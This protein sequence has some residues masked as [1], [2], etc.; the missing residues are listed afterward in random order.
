[1]IKKF[2]P[3]DFRKQDYLFWPKFINT[4]LVSKNV[5]KENFNSIQRA[6]NSIRAMSFSLPD[7]DAQ[8]I[9]KDKS[10]I[11]TINNLPKDVVIIKSG[12]THGIVLSKTFLVFIQ[13][14][15]I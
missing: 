13:I 14:P 5:Q 3:V 12:K 2:N 8:Q 4:I 11:A 6:K 15:D 10:K 9:I 1:M 7:F